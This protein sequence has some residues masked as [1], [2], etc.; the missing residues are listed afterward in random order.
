VLTSRAPDLDEV[1]RQAVALL[2][3]EYLAG[4]QRALAAQ[5][6]TV[7]IATAG[8]NGH[9]KHYTTSTTL[10]AGSMYVLSQHF[11]NSLPKY[12]RNQ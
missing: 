1:L 5:H 2:K 3:I 11:G 6:H 8:S 10:H 7:H 4:A 12:H 9:S